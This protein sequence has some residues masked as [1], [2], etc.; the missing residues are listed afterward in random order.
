MYSSRIW[1]RNFKHH[2]KAL[3]SYWIRSLFHIYLIGKK[4]PQVTQNFDS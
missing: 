3:N 2:P 4:I 1:T